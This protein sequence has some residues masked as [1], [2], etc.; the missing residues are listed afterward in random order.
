MRL[1]TRMTFLPEGGR[2]LEPPNDY[3]PADDYRPCAYCGNDFDP[4]KSKLCVVCNREGHREHFQDC[5]ICLE[6]VCEHCAVGNNWVMADG[7]HCCGQEH[8]IEHDFDLMLH[9]VNR[10]IGERKLCMTH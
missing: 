4:E 6:S 2:L 5:P 3:D 9:E 10:E 7:N 8:V 1:R